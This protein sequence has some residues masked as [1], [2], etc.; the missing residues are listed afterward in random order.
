VFFVEQYKKFDSDGIPT[1]GPMDKELSE[2][3]RNKLKK[4]HKK[5][6]DVHQKWLKES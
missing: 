2:S 3:I 1:H 6:D 5:Q 4:E